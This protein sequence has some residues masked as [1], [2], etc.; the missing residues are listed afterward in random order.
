MVLFSSFSAKCVWLT[1]L[2]WVTLLGY[3][4]LLYK[5][6]LYEKVCWE[7]S[8]KQSQKHYYRDAENCGHWLAC[9]ESA[10]LQLVTSHR[11]QAISWPYTTMYVHV[12]YL[13]FFLIT[14]VL[15]LKLFL[16]QLPLCQD[17]PRDLVISLPLGTVL[18]RSAQF[19]CMECIC[20]IDLDL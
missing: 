14:A 16:S 12:K 2:F 15:S 19:P 17:A 13:K 5:V 4:V 7:G 10:A 9:P 18:Y 11:F 3:I 8:R 1:L 20:P 6:V